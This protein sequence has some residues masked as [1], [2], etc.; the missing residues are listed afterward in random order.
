MGGGGGG[1]AFNQ[2]RTR[3]SGLFDAVTPRPAAGVAEP[4][5][6]TPV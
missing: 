2:A 1:A 3:V 5:D 6:R 4:G